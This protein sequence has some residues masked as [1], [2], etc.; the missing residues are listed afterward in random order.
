M[1]KEERR[2]EEVDADIEE[3]SR[4]FSQQPGSVWCL[5]YISGVYSRPYLKT[6]MDRS[7]STASPMFDRLLPITWVSLSI[8]CRSTST[9]T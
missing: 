2:E 3:G 7:T 8:T 4:D 6:R 1:L 5:R 9:A